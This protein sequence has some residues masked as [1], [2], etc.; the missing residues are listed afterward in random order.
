[1]AGVQAEVAKATT[2]T[3]A[4]KVLDCI[5]YTFSLIIFFSFFSFSFGVYIS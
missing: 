4:P 2:A 3:A 5:L 1:M